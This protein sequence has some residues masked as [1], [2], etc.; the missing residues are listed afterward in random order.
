[1]MSID[2][3][4]FLGS[5]FIE[6]ESWL[7][8]FCAMRDSGDLSCSGLREELTVLQRH[9]NSPL[10]GMRL[11]E[12]NCTRDALFC[13]EQGCSDFSAA[14]VHYSE[15]RRGLSWESR[16]DVKGD[17]TRW[18]WASFQHKKRSGAWQDLQDGIREMPYRALNRILYTFPNLRRPEIALAAVGIFLVQLFVIA[19]VVKDGFR[20]DPFEKVE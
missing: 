19:W 11:A 16:Y 10:H 18:A 12:V 13:Q 15:G 20:P 3:R 9:E 14:V 4:D 7:I 2:R 1:M 8:L 6:S 5:A 17:L